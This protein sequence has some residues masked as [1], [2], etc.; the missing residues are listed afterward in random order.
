VILQHDIEGIPMN[1]IASANGVSLS[2]AYRWRVRGFARLRQLLSADE[3]S[4]GEDDE[5]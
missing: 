5:E 2:T 3:D 1:E 4:A